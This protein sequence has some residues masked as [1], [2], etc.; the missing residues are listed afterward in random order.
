MNGTR[1]GF[2][3]IFYFLSGNFPRNLVS[4]HLL[5]RELRLRT[6]VC[7]QAMQRGRN[8]HAEDNRDA[9]RYRHY[10]HIRYGSS[11]RHSP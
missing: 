1:H 6:R 5:G 8:L 2:D 9:E 3:A 10:Q 11:G 7:Q 4:D